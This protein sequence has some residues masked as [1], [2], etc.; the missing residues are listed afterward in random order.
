MASPRQ[1]PRILLGAAIALLVSISAAD[2]GNW[3]AWRGP[4]GNGVTKETELPTEWSATKNVRWKM[5]LPERGNST[6]IVWG[7]KV[8]LTQADGDDRQLYCVNR[9]DGTLRWKSSVT[10]KPGEPTH[11]T[12]PYCSSA[13]VTD[14][15][16]A[17]CGLFQ[18]TLKELGVPALTDV[19]P[20]LMAALDDVATNGMPTK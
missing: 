4:E 19:D 16:A 3:P 1:L 20:A 13:P 10:A 12:N 2:A 15:E 14:G 18:P 11:D 9:K 8:F 6:P 5:P 7:D 17:S